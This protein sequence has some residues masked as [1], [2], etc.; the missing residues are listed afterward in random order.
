MTALAAHPFQNFI[1]VGYSTGQ[2]RGYTLNPDT[3]P[4]IQHFV[5]WHST[6]VQALTFTHD[7]LHLLSGGEE[8]WLQC[9]LSNLFRQFWLCSTRRQS[10]LVSFPA[11]VA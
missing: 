4:Q 7:G 1:A 8:A 9:Y 11:W 2:I 6:P 3:S 10:D 5:H